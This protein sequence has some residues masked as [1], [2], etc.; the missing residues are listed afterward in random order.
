MQSKAQIENELLKLNDKRW[1]ANFKR[2]RFATCVR[3][4]YLFVRLFDVFFLLKFL[5]HV[6]PI[7]E[8]LLVYLFIQFYYRSVACLFIII[9]FSFVDVGAAVFS[10]VLSIHIFH[11]H[12]ALHS[13]ERHTIWKKQRL[14][15]EQ[16]V[17]QSK[18]KRGAKKSDHLKI[19]W[20]P[21]M[22]LRSTIHIR[23]KS[24]YMISCFSL[25][26]EYYWYIFRTCLKMKQKC[27]EKES[28]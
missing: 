8:I 28:K 2:E 3:S 7:W 25:E 26:Y 24:F 1:L 11:K 15:N 17:L 14:T 13:G 23:I 12:N 4:L 5:F 22:L 20:D 19:I 27:R 6:E 21:K 18:Q 9:I 16:T 10:N